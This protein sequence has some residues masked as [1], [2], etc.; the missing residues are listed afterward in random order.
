MT[1]GQA[2]KGFNLSAWAL[3]NQQLVAF[4]MLMVMVLG[5]QSYQGLSRNEDPAFTIKT[6]V[7]SAGWPGASI[8]DTSNFVTEVLEKKLQETPHLDFVESY[9][10]PGEA[11]IFVNL[12]DDTPPEQ[13]PDVWYQVRKKIHDISPTLP[14][15]V[16]TPQVNDEFA[17]TFGTI[18]GFV[19]DGFSDRELRDYVD[20]V[21]T[22]L[23]QVPD[24]GKIELLG[25]N[26]EQIVL[27]FSN[28]KLAG[29]GL[30]LN[31]VIQS[32]QAQNAVIPAG[33]IRTAQD[34]VT[35]QVSGALGSEQSLA[36]ITL[37]IADRFIALPE[38]AS[39]KRQ[40]I[41]PPASQ[42]RVNGEPAIGLAISMADGG[43]ML[44][45]GQALKQKMADV[46]AQLPHGIDMHQVADQAV[47]VKDAVSGFIK[48]LIEA[49]VIVL[50]VSFVSL[51]SR[52]GLVV[53]VSVPLVLA[54]TFIGM[55]WV[56]I[57]LQRISLGA[58]IIALGLL[59]DDAM[60]TVETMVSRLEHGWARA[61]AASYAYETTAFPMLTGTLVMVAGFIPV[62]FAASSAGE[63]CFSL[64]VVVL[65][66]LLSSWLVAVLFSPLL[67]V[68]LLPATM[69]AHQQHQG[70]L[71]KTFDQVLALALRCRA[72]TLAIA[73]AALLGATALSGLMKEE[74]FPASD[75]PELLVSLTLPQSSSQQQ[76]LKRTV[77]LEQLL[78]KDPDVTHFSSYVGSGAI[79]F[80][81]P[82]DVLLNHE[83]IAQLVV[84]TKDLAA[85]EAV[86]A[87]LEDIMRA[88]F[89]DLVTRVSPLELGPPVGWPLKWRVLGP[90]VAKVRELALELSTVIGAHPQSRDVNLS[91][92]DPQRMLQVAIDQT[93]ARAV[94]LSSSD[95]ASALATV[96][97]GQ[98]ITAIRDGNRLIDVTVKG[99]DRERTNI[100]TVE[101][102][103]IRTAAG[104]TVPLRQ[105]AKVYYDLADPIVWRYQRQ[106]FVYVQ[107][108]VAPGTPALS[109][110]QELQQDINTFRAKLPAGY[111]L[112][113]KGAVAEAAKGNTSVYA[114]LPLTLVVM[115]L[116][117]MIQ[118]RRVSRA[119][120]SVL[121]A[122]FGL[123]GIVLAML[124]TGTPMGFVALLGIIALAGM[125]IRNAVIL[126]EEVDS[127]VAAGQGRDEAIINAAR[128]RSRP[129]VL[130]A[131][132]A[133]LGMLPIAGQVFWGPMA[134]AIIGGLAVATVLTLTLLPVALSL[135]MEREGTQ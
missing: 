51:G 87:R 23:M 49:I 130:T 63:Y 4:L 30:D 67:G 115:L 108:D 72:A 27:E 6:A 74:F 20:N 125:I 38:I 62:G 124:P 64:F 28:Q 14:Q 70:R 133:I 134:F 100:Q 36:Q 1:T 22:A 39:I 12:R 109:V 5:I 89:D 66:A 50:A 113:E 116:L 19:A 11:V 18:Y 122:P 91:A 9:T 46:N 71:S 45:F 2:S 26:D 131:C 29:L 127:N 31:Q 69:A 86:K 84:V 17:D 106:P 35:L 24:V 129:I 41:D 80:Y 135:L 48:V 13:V 78:R 120:V 121:M 82:M 15:G 90:D 81:L 75:R 128:H 97:S 65:I 47:V 94:G 52:A 112:E 55:E 58:L 37:R 7:V 132:A 42:F 73:V 111:Q 103:Q 40:Y 99:D 25:V 105:V 61:K 3:A 101:N 117:L 102:L 56:G 77:Q 79:R 104:H 126:I 118:L 16:S 76:T 32:I 53:A 68:W 60:I 21:R 57:G 44:Q 83:H 110:V 59:V 93:Q 96:F 43:N 85:R 98:S 8:Q 95:I 88:Q 34:R 119:L 54:M 123:I 33:V 10:R 107:A 92:G 114:V